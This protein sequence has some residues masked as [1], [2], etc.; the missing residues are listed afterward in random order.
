M[1]TNEMRKEEAGLGKR[2]IWVGQGGGGTED[3]GAQLKK[4]RE[5]PLN[6]MC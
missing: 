4:P 6:G 2:L 3:E 5:C 1:H